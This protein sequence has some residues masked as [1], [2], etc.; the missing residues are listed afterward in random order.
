MFEQLLSVFRGVLPGL[1]AGSAFG[2]LGTQLALIVVRG[3]LHKLCR[4]LG[5]PPPSWGVREIFHLVRGPKFW[6][7]IRSLCRRDEAED[8]RTLMHV[9]EVLLTVR[10]ASVRVVLVSFGLMLLARTFG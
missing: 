4:K 9:A 6:D 8:L 10:A 7:H 1:M 2:C 3:K 5:E